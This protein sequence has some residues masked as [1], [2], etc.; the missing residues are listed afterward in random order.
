MLL[1]RLCLSHL[2]TQSLSLH[3]HCRPSLWR[4]GRRD[5][6]DTHAQLFSRLSMLLSSKPRAPLSLWTNDD[7]DKSPS[8]RPTYV[9]FL[10]DVEGDGEY[11]DRFVNH[12][13]LLGFRTVTPSFGGYGKHRHGEYENKFDGETWNL[14]RYDE[15][16]FPYDKDI[17]FLD[18]DGDSG[19][20]NSMLVYGVSPL[21][22]MF[23][24]DSVPSVALIL[25]N[26]CV[27]YL[28]KGDIWDKGGSDLYVL[29]QL[30]SLRRRYPHRVFFLM[31][32]RDINKMRIVDELGVSGGKVE[33]LPPHKGAYWLMR[34][35][36]SLNPERLV[37][38]NE[39]AAERVKWMLMMTMG[40][41]NAFE[42]RRSE[43]IRERT[44][45]LNGIAVVP[46]R[47]S[48][49][50]NYDDSIAIKVTDDEVAQSYIHSC[51]PLSG[52]MSQCK[53]GTCRD[54]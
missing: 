29:R 51:C 3:R 4:S 44:S 52:I 30:L 50:A 32:N 46:S 36:L 9:T 35:G 53:L 33:S 39:S 7:E 2:D 19:Y 12:S 21:Q 42:L 15:D 26:V 37:V 11:L 49:C 38:P 1:R 23:C 10:T 22:Y 31:G 27:I 54:V 24:V 48:V 8:Q 13:K 25:P 18:D 20:H 34:S 40:S 16:Y 14:G 41:V 43:L 45:I 28:I 5:G 6:C 47:H 17:I